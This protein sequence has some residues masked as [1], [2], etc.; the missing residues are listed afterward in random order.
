VRLRPRRLN[1]AIAALFMIGSFGFALGCVSAYA[2]A[3]GP[4]ADAVTFF[5]SSI[6]FTTASFWQLVQSQS[7]AVAASGTAHDVEG[8]PVR[9]V[10]W[11]P[12][13]KAWPAAATQFPGTLFFN[14]TTFWAITIAVSNSQ[15]DKVVW[16]PDFYGSV[17]FLVSS[18]FALLA[19]GRL[20]TWRPREAAWWAAWLNMLGSIAFMASAIAAF[21]IPRTGT[22][23]DLTL[24]DRGT[25]VGA[26]C[27]FVG[28]LLAITAWRQAAKAARAAADRP[29]PSAG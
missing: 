20:V 4:T 18:A 3:V 7:P 2:A 11:L 16:R 6:F 21:V 24:A 14:G 9:F 15:Y 23:V 1:S 25:L 8:Q 13:D 28:A 27:F 12:H 19:L 5:V 10:S 29:A 22:S 17:L 26:V